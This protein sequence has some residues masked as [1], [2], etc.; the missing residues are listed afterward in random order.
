[1][2]KEKKRSKI[3]KL[4]RKIKKSTEPTPKVLP[5]KLDRIP[6]YVYH[7]PIIRPDGSIS[8]NVDDN[9]AHAVVMRYI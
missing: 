2:G 3:R 6:V 4:F 5:N 9:G 8:F 7:N 1:M